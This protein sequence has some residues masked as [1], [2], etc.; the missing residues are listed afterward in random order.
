MFFLFELMVWHDLY[1]THMLFERVSHLHI[2][3]LLRWLFIYLFVIDGIYLCLAIIRYGFMS[4]TG[5]GQKLRTF[6]VYPRLL[7][8]YVLEHLHEQCLC[9]T[10]L[11]FLFFLMVIIWVPDA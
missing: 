8:D 10:T 3:L 1:A 6:L 11:L 7:I 9:C 2:Y 5:G 4:E